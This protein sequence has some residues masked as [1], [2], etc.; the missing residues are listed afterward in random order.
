VFLS[1]LIVLSYYG[2]YNVGAFNLQINQVIRFLTIGIVI[3]FIYVLIGI[4]LFRYCYIWRQSM[5]YL[6]MWALSRGSISYLFVVS[7]CAGLIEEAYTRGL[8]LLIYLTNYGSS[9]INLSKLIII[10]LL[11]NLLWAISHILNNKETFIAHPF[12]AFKQA[13]PHMIVIFLSGIPWYFITLTTGSLIPAIISHFLL[14]FGM[15]VFYRHQLRK[16]SLQQKIPQLY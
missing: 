12:L 6:E 14:D 2:L 15:G 3:G 13:T 1:L 9:G 8:I 11:L 7:L 5:E 10:A 4:L 16:E